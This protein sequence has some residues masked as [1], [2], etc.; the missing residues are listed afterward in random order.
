M[1]DLLGEEPPEV[2]EVADLWDVLVEAVQSLLTGFAARVPLFVLGILV[3]VLALVATRL[4][5]GARSGGSGE[6]G[7]TT[8]SSGSSPT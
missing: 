1:E 8:P 4:L 7:S 3:L 5:I 2:R 6:H